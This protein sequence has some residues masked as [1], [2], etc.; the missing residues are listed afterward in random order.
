[1]AFYS[2]LSGGS[3]ST[4]TISSAG[5]GYT[6]APSGTYLTTTGIYPQWTSAITTP[7][8]TTTSN[9]SSIT[10]KGDADFE[11]DIKFKGRSLAESLEAIEKRLAILVP[12][13]KKLEKYEALQKAYRNYKLLEALCGDDDDNKD[14]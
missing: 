1:M 4:V 11:G 5:S 14:K 9:G 10:V 6:T 13:P 12:D 2:T 7:M 8:I 3:T